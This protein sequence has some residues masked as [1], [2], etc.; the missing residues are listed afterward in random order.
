[1]SLALNKIILAS[2]TAN[3]PGA[4]L[5]I[6]TLAATNVGNVIPAGMYIMFPTANV[7]INAVNA[8]NATTGNVTSQALVLA[9]NTGG[10]IFSDGVNVFANATTNTTVTFL[11][12]DGGQN[13]SGTYNNV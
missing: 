2:A 9:N 10:V 5:Q 11:T 3:T 12:I 4:Y 8:V 7:T 13:V 1:M 6:Q